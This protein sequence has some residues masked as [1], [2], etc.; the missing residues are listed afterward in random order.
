MSR[1]AILEIHKDELKFSAGHFMLFSDKKRE[2]MHGHD[3]Q[4]H[5]IFHT[6]ILD[7][8]MSFDVRDYKTKL[9]ALCQ[10]LDYRFILPSKSK[11]LR[12]EHNNDQCIAHYGQETL[13][14]YQKDISV[15]PIC[16]VTL[17]ELSYW[18]LEQLLLNKEELTSNGIQGITIKVYNGRGDSGGSSFGTTLLQP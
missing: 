9:Q 7:N 4:V 10:K 6:T 1:S 18:F 17:E 14:F 5:A 2:S 15:L 16:N 12:L 13:T 8:G 3:Y 11:F